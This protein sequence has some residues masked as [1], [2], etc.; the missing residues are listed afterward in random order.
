M[1]DALAS[2][3]SEGFLVGV[4]VPPRPRRSSCSTGSLTVH[5]ERGVAIDDRLPSQLNG[6]D[7]VIWDLLAVAAGPIR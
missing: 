3:A 2:G 4:Q 7:E 5:H 1:A 6:I